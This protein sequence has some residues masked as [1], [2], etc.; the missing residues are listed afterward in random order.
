MRRLDHSKQPQDGFT[1]IELIIVIVII[2]ILA[3]VAIPKFQDLTNDAK[4]GSANGFGAAMSSASATNY[5]A[6]AGKLSSAVSGLNTC[7]KL[8]ALMTG[9]T[10]PTGAT[11]SG[12]T[13]D[14]TGTSVSC[15]I[16]STDF[17]G[18]VTFPGWGTPASCS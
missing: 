17:I 3:A 5:S 7:S 15:T 10:L 13:L 12:T 11:I 14:T 16:T 18:T 6:C 1:L 2:G 9:S 8:S 4:L